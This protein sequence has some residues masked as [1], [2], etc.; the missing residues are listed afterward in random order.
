MERKEGIF[1]TERENLLCYALKC[2]AHWC[3]GVCRTQ[4][5]D[6]FFLPSGGFLYG[7]DL[8]M[9]IGFFTYKLT[10][11]KVHSGGN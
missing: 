8:G 4:Y 5:K 10:A 9:G 1:D 6:F 3:C 7:D 11:A 2:G